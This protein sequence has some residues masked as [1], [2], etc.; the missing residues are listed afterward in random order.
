MAGRGGVRRRTGGGEGGRNARRRE[1]NIMGAKRVGG[2]AEGG[3]ELL[4][5][6]KGFKLAMFWSQ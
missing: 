5:D 4:R 1:G 2:C 6:L 3:G